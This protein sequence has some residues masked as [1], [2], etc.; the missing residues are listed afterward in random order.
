MSETKKVRKAR[1]RG[2][3]E[4]IKCK[5]K[6]RLFEERS[7]AERRWGANIYLSNTAIISLSLT[8][9]LLFSSRMRLS[10]HPL[11]RQPCFCQNPQSC[12]NVFDFAFTVCVCVCGGLIQAMKSGSLQTHHSRW[13][14]AEHQ[15]SRKDIFYQWNFRSRLWF[16]PLALCLD[17][18]SSKNIPLNRHDKR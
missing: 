15:S 4:E 11:L 7:M 6:W 1:W 17:P 16:F 13:G 3:L 8:P 2:R 14:S 5:I 18:S 9:N 12:L 10:V